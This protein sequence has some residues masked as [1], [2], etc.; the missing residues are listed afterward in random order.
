MHI[1]MLDHLQKWILHSM[2]T[3][4]RLDKYNAIWLSLPAY[5]DITSKNKYYEDVFHR[6]GKEMKEMSQDLHGVVTQSQRGGRPTQHRKFNRAIE[7][8]RASLEF[9]MYALYKYHNDGTLSCM[10]DALHRFYTF[11]DVFLL[12]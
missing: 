7:C 11:K 2:K 9:Y 12:G 10:E 1:G 8:T 4:E 5:H 3:P 6:N